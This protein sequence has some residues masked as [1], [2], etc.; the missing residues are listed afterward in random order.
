MSPLIHNRLSTPLARL[1][2]VG[3]GVLALAAVML[4]S[5]SEVRGAPCS[6]CYLGCQD[7]HAA[8]YQACTNTFNDCESDAEATYDS[9][10]DL[11]FFETN[12]VLRAK[13]R[14]DAETKYN[15]A[16]NSCRLSGAACQ[17]NANTAFWQCNSNCAGA[18]T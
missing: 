6:N 12:S 18:S 2:A 9:D 17:L 1:F 16:L 13:C 4:A 14:Q 8:A 11:C 5:P 7:A 15:T 10:Y 3:L